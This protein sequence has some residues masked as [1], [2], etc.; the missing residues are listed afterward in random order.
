M[1]LKLRTIVMKKREPFLFCTP[2]K[3]WPTLAKR[4]MQKPA[5]KRVTISLT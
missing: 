5:V 3:S 4:M 2:A 1:A